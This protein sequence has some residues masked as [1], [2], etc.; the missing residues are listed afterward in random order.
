MNK[1]T[2]QHLEH[3]NPH[4]IALQ[5]QGD[6][7]AVRAMT[8]LLSRQ[9]RYNAYLEGEKWVCRV[10]WLTQQARRFHNLERALTLAQTKAAQKELKK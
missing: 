6:D 8:E 4:W 2:I 7:Q 10:A 3:I 5:F 9:K 1:L